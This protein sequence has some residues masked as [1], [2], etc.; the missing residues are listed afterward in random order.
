MKRKNIIDQFAEFLTDNYYKEMALASAKG[1]KSLQVDISLLDKL[2][3]DLADM[4]LDSPK[5]TIEIFEEAVEQIDVPNKKEFKIR[6]F[7]MP[8]SGKIR[9]RNIRS[10]H[11][12]KFICVDGI[13]KRASEVRPEVAET[14]FECPECGE[15]NSYTNRTEQNDSVSN[16]M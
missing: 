15:N 13:V 5:K 4:L 2:N 7:N 9:I 1:K 16:K 14:I 6:F 8:E 12:G 11:I 10:E 3:P